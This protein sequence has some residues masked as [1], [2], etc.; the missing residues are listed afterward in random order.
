VVERP[1]DPALPAAQLAYARLDTHYLIPLR[2]KVAVDLNEG[3]LWDSAREVFEKACEQEA[4]LKIFHPEA[5]IQIS[6]A[7]TLDATGKRIL[8][9]LYL[10]REHEA[11]RR[12]RAPFRILSDDTL[13]RLA[14]QRPKN[15]S[16]F[17]KIKG[18]PRTYHNG[19]ASQNLLELIR[20]TEGFMEEMHIGN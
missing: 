8:K 18:I 20:K 4:Q 15:S 13:L 2:Q 6:G 16:D 12:N 10:Y 17:F 5:F 3:Q 7:R 11:R 1:A 9:A 19:H 14:R